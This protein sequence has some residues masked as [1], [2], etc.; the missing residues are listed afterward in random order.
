MHLASIFLFNLAFPLFY[1][2]SLC[3]EDCK[4]CCDPSNHRIINE[5]RRSINSIWKPGQKAI[6]D[7][8]LPWGWYRFTSYVG[9]EM[10]TSRVSSSHCGTVA[11]IWLRGDHPMSPEREVTVQACINFFDISNGCYQPF[12][13]KIRLC[14]GSSSFYIYYL[15]PTYSCAVAYCAGKDAV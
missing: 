11:P 6:C 4:G 3:Q 9:G 13:V 5:P 12:D 1:E 7:S 14:S 2:L 10:P 15:R 8:T